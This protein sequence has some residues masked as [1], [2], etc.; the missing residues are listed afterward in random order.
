[1][2]L[3]EP[4]LLKKILSATSLI[5]LFNSL[6]LSVGFLAMY[7]VLKE[8]I[9]KK[10]LL[11]RASSLLEISAILGGLFYIFSRYMIGNYDIAL[12]YHN[13]VFLNPL[14]FYLFLKYLLTHNMRYMWVILVL[15][16]IFAS[17]F[18]FLASPVLF[19]FYPI[20]VVFLFMYVLFIKKQK[21]PW[22][23]ILGGFFIFTL[24]QGFHIVP[25]LV[26]VFYPGSHVHFRLF[27]Q[28]DLKDEVGI[29][30]GI[31]AIAKL[32]LN[33][34]LPSFTKFFTIFSF[35]T[36]LVIILGILLNKKKE[37]TMLLT[38]AFFLVI[39]FF[40]S[41]RVLWGGA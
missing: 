35:V 33:I 17:S 24:L 15:S 8:I 22:K 9:P 31:L 38:S 29:F 34:F 41:G 19:A 37:K 10:S 18:G 2:R 3:Y 39:F 20:S 6:K 28:Q 23:G 40:L 5:T 16:F 7:L 25:L 14:M 36:P 4:V 12:L 26:D 13:Q 32:S 11:Q 30:F 27:N 21:I 1:M